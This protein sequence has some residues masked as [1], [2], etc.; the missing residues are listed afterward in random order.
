[1]SAL[2]D[3]RVKFLRCRVCGRRFRNTD[4]AVERIVNHMEMRHAYEV[5]G[6]WQEFAL[7]LKQAERELVEMET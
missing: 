2:S 4:Y 5:L 7:L 6:F 1:M 3:P